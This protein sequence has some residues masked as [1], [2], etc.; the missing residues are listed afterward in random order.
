MAEAAKIRIDFSRMHD[1]VTVN[2]PVELR[3]FGQESWHNLGKCTDLSEGGLGITVDA[4]FRVGEIVELRFP[5]AEQEIQYR[6]RI[7]YRRN[8]FHYGIQ[9]VDAV[10][11]SGS[12]AGAGTLLQN[13]THG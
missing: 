7:I 9:F 10:Y 3:R 8:S 11:P 5:G 2:A 13:P 4:T 6:A 1:R 12:S